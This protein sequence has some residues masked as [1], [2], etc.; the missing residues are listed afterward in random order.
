M[1]SSFSLSLRSELAERA[2]HYALENNLSGYESIGAMPA[3]LFEPSVP[4]S[5]HG[6]FVEGS[7]R[8][9]CA[10]RSWSTR[11]NKV[12]PQLAALP[13]EKRQH[14]KEMDSCNSSDALLMN[15]FCYPKAAA[16]IIS[17]FFPGH[18]V[19]PVEFGVAGKVALM[20]GSQDATEIDMKIGPTIFEAKLTETDFTAR[21]K[22]HVVRYKRFRD[23]F[24]PDM[25]RQTTDEYCGYQL[26]RNVLAAEQYGWRF[27]VICDAR[28]PDLLREWWVVHAAIREEFLRCRCGFL[29]W[30]EIALAC[31]STL[32]RFLRFKYGLGDRG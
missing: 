32:T 6:N 22:S 2:K 26:I 23:V 24:N 28:R 15:C 16:R 29:L 8:A 3:Y 17:K 7:Y 25:L 11:L 19:E 5:Q 4:P 14:A 12:H 27:Y 21:P 30:Q 1:T 10:D 9:I 13:E 20:D 31:P 18:A